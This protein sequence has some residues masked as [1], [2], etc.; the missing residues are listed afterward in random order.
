MLEKCLLHLSCCS[1]TVVHR[2]PSSSLMVVR[3]IGTM[4]LLPCM[5]ISIVASIPGCA[6]ECYYRN[7]R[8]MNRILALVNG[9]E[10]II[11]NIPKKTMCPQILKLVLYTICTLYLSCMGTIQKCVCCKND[12]C[13]QTLSSVVQSGTFL[14]Y[15]E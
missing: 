6:E 9:R 11:I 14:V 13:K 15:R 7:Y 1:W 8:H 5:H 2:W 10:K 3:L 12:R 4:P